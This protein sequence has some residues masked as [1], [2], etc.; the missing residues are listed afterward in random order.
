MVKWVIACFG[1]WMGGWSDQE[2]GGS[3]FMWVERQ[4][5][6]KGEWMFIMD[7]WMLRWRRIYGKRIL[8]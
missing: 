2:L 3:I 5:V 4:T 7:E 1:R 8:E 6:L